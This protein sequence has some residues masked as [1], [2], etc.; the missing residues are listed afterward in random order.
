MRPPAVFPAGKEM[1]ESRH[2]DQELGRERETSSTFHFL[3]YVS[4][5]LILPFVRIEINGVG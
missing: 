3:L 1:D 5:P 4:S 2:T